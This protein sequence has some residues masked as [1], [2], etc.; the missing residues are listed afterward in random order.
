M[1]NT[2]TIMDKAKLKGYL[3]N[4]TV[5]SDFFEFYTAKD[6]VGGYLGSA[7]RTM[8]RDKAMETYL[9]IK[10]LRDNG[11]AFIL[12][13]KDGS[14]MMALINESTSP[15]EFIEKMKSTF[16]N[17]LT[18][19]YE[20]VYESGIKSLSPIKDI[21]NETNKEEIEEAIKLFIRMKRDGVKAPA[22]KAKAP[23][24]ENSWEGRYEHTTDGHDKFWEIN[25]NAW[26]KYSFT[27]RWGKNGRPPQ[28]T[29]DDYGYDDAVK[30]VREKL[31][32]GYVKIN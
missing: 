28:G 16:S 18:T 7:D 5:S 4:E 22:P 9:R 15:N 29:K 10:G 12:A 11:I 27:A 3:S 21:P 25:Q 26:R 6:M 32:K 30:L 20:I 17:P 23:T 19:V 31:A 8:F 1:R 24:R 14:K 2:N 13:G